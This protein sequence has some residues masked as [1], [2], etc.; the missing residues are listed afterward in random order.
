MTQNIVNITQIDA[1]QFQYQ[2]FGTDVAYV[3]QTD[4][5]G[6]DF[7]LN[8][9]N[10]VELHVYNSQNVL[11]N[12]VSPFTNYNIVG[13]E[14]VVDPQKDLESVGYVE[15]KYTLYYNFLTPLLGNVFNPLYIH[16]S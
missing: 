15:G 3:S 11:V 6:V 16:L 12:Q 9:N 4:Q 10:Y 1:K 5:T 7:T 8:T 14:V 13:I 2:V